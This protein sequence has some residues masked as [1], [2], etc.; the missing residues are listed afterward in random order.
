MMV[1]WTKVV[2]VKVMASGQILETEPTKFADRLGVSWER[3]RGIKDF[4]SDLSPPLCYQIN[5]RK[6]HI[7][8]RIAFIM[9]FICFIYLLIFAL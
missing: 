2:M 6:I 1:A 5:V 3:K 9:S 8:S 4:F 7:V